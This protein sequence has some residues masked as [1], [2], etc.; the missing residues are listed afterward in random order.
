MKRVGFLVFLALLLGACANNPTVA[1][2]L[3]PPAPTTPQTADART[4]AELHTQLGAGYFELRNFPVALDELN[5]ALRADPEYGPAH[6]ML[7]LLYMELREDALAEQS[8]ERALRINAS[9]SDAH[10]N[11]GWFLCQ[12]KRYDPALK[13]FMAAVRNPLYQTPDKSY[14]NAGVCMRERGD[15][16]AAAELFER[17]LSLQPGQPEALYQLADLAFKR[18]QASASKEY[19]TRLSRT[20]VSLGADALWLALR[21]ERRLGDRDAEASYGLQLRRNFPNSP[22]AQALLNRQYE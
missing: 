16:A 15:D 10:N 5:E 8:F 13:H 3:Q 7:G 12:R 20:G 1:P 6:N 11:Y 22:Q 19:L 17:A 9:D 4:R 14:V 18:G 21:V 2:T